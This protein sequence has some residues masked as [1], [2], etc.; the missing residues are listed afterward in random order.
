MEPDSRWSLTPDFFCWSSVMAVRVVRR[1]G[2]L[3]VRLALGR[4]RLYS[5]VWIQGLSCHL[6][7]ICLVPEF[8]RASSCCADNM[9]YQP[10]PRMPAPHLQ[11]VFCLQIMRVWI[12]E[13]WFLFSRHWDVFPSSLV[14]HLHTHRIHLT[15]TPQLHG[16]AHDSVTFSH[17]MSLHS[18]PFSYSHFHSLIPSHPHPTSSIHSFSLLPTAPFIHSFPLSRTP[19]SFIHVLS[20]T[21]YKSWPGCCSA[22]RNLH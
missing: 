13:A 10:N 19:T 12:A 22:E 16:H 21:R 9:E 8:C 14:S 5:W 3:G 7:W 4:E 11:F 15:P 20:P 6:V 17:W 18:F 2:D 1:T